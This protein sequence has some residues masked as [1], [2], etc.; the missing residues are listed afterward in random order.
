MTVKRFPF[1]HTATTSRT[2]G[3]PIP[4]YLEMQRAVPEATLAAMTPPT[5]AGQRRG[6]SELVLGRLVAATGSKLLGVPAKR[7]VCSQYDTAR[8]GHEPVV[9]ISHSYWTRRCGQF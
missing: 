6:A 7:A 9:V 3:S 5:H 2:C 1:A 8:I 4:L